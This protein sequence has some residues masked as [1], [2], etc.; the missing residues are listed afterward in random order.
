[1]RSTPVYQQAFYDAIQNGT[2]ASAAALLPYVQERVQ[3]ASVIDV[4]CGTGT[5][6][7]VWKTAGVIDICGLDGDYIQKEQ[8]LIPAENFIATDL[9]KPFPVKNQYELV[10]SLEVAEHL[11]TDQAGKFIDSLCQLG[12]LILFSAAVPAQ[13]GYHHFNEQY[14]SYWTDLFLKNGFLPFDCLRA[15]IWNISSIDK[16]Y[17][18]NILFF[19]KK[20]AI[21]KYPRITETNSAPLDIVHP[22]YLAD[23]EAEIKQLKK[24]LKNPFRIIGYY[25]RALQRKM[26]KKEF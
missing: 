12:D 17:R 8:L 15:A 19:V 11:P 3:P 21:H 6:L 9:T 10:M 2:A 23:K 14:P 24:I 20:E 25:F 16:C 13:G 5:W 18:Q 22:E 1:M 7:A 4:G 26:G